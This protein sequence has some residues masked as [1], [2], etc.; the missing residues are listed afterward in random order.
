MKS[1]DKDLAALKAF[2]RGSREAEIEMFGKSINHHK[3]F[4][5]KKIYSRKNYKI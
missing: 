1:K 3:V 2:K 4:K 5:S